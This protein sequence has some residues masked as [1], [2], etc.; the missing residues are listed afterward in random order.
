MTTEDDEEEELLMPMVNYFSKPLFL[1]KRLTHGHATNDV[2]LQVFDRFSRI[3]PDLKNFLYAYI[4]S[5]NE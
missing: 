3:D 1:T 4:N 2:R 5:D